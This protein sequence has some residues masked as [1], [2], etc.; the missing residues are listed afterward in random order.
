MHL[1]CMLHSLEFKIL[2]CAFLLLKTE[3]MRKL[4]VLSH[5]QSLNVDYVFTIHYMYTTLQ[6]L[7]PTV[8]TCFKVQSTFTIFKCLFSKKAED[9]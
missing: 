4:K 9:Y 1:L 8:D 7:E 6:S 5:V 3:I 2:H